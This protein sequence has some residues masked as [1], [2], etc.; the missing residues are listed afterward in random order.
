MNRSATVLV[1]IVALTLTS[2]GDNKKINECNALVGVIN[3]AVQ[4]IRKHT[5]TDPDGGND[6]QQLRLLADEME[7][8]SG[9][10]EKIELSFP[11]LKKY[12]EEYQ[13]MATEVASSARE[14]AAA[15]D[16]VDIE[17]IKKARSRM[18]KAVKR[19]DPLVEA[20]NKYCRSP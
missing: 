12:S 11:E 10:A 18:D 3:D 5:S 14:L 15:Y 1:A 13:Q 16:K 2:C 19:E 4:K 9:E 8:V 20:L 17:G 6:M 7:A